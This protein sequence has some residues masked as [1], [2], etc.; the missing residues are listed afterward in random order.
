VTIRESEKLRSAIRL[1]KEG[2]LM[3]HR[4]FQ[5]VIAKK[6]FW[7]YFDLLHDNGM[8]SPDQNPPPIEGDSPGQFRIPYWSALDYLKAVAKHSASASDVELAKKVLGVV[9]SISEAIRNGE[10]ARDNYYTSHAFIEILSLVPPEA[11]TDEVVDLVPIWLDTRFDQSLAGAAFADGVLVRLADAGAVTASLACRILAHLTVVE[12]KERGDASGNR[13]FKSKISDYWLHKIANAVSQKLG[14]A[15]HREALRPFEAA[16]RKLTASDPYSRRSDLLRPAIEDHEQ[17]HDWDHLSNALVEGYRD[18]LI[19]WID[20][21]PA[22]AATH[23]AALLEDDC[24]LLRRISVHAINS[25]FE[26]LK[27]LYDQVLRPLWLT[28]DALHELYVL[29]ATQFAGISSEL[30]RRTVETIRIIPHQGEEDEL[31]RKILQ[32]RWLSAI[33]QKGSAEAD[34]WYADLTSNVGVP[35]REHPSFD[36]YMEVGW[37]GGPSP[38]SPP[39]LIQAVR[40]G[41]IV[42]LLNGFQETRSWKGPTI[43]SLVDAVA[44]AV[45]IDPMRFW[46]ALPEFRNAKIA[47]Q[48]GII[49]GFKKVWDAEK[50]DSVTEQW[51]RGWP[52]LFDFFEAVLMNRAFWEAPLEETDDLRPTRLWFVALV[53]DFLRAGTR[54]DKKAYP[55]TLLPRGW[56]LIQ[57]L[58]AEGKQRPGS[59]GNVEGPQQELAEDPMTAAINSQNGKAVEALIIHALRVCR[60]AD[61]TQGSHTIEWMDMEPTFEQEL[62]L[63][64]GQNFEFSTLMGAYLPQV[65]YMSSDWRKRNFKRIFPVESPSNCLS[66]LGGLAFANAT[67][68]I[69]Q[70]LSSNGIFAWALRHARSGTQ[71]REK[72]LQRLSLGYLWGDEPLHGELFSQLLVRIRTE[73]LGIVAQFYW[74]LSNQNLEPEQKNRILEFWAA[75][76]T[77]EIAAPTLLLAKLG[78]LAVYIDNISERE[79]DL[80]LAVAPHIASDHSADFFIEQLVRFAD[81]EPNDVF[82]ILTKM[83]ETYRPVYDFEGRLKQLLK[84]LREAGI[85]EVAMLR[86]TLVPY[87]PQ[88]RTLD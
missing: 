88:L 81:A 34:A 26:Q 16:L 40:G 31:G 46:P 71:T 78:L 44:E 76:L 68:E 57:L 48:Y 63:C 52:A 5:I 15:A 58:L 59:P 27:H 69:H 60:V 19:G 70:L 14:A 75:C 72:L 1:M 18:A 74:S 64:L 80:L 2:P 61:Q 38:Y 84:T 55:S 10:S 17:N 54:S 82:A 33:V 65:G 7:E 53:S 13:E 6:D 32:V 79:R 56:A 24:S 28:S 49:E 3:A 36:V 22:N 85:V 30:K 62:A 51:N 41:N 42:D 11:I 37:G 87:L 21:D 43:R 47:Y 39:E 83:L 35:T 4:G 66:A 12:P 77:P 86:D 25:R 29:L 50:D 23:V 20:S 8:F 73:D 67:L 45:V 9:Q